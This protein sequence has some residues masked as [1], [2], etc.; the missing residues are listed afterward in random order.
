[1]DD[2]RTWCRTRHNGGLEGRPS[3]SWHV[4]SH[5]ARCSSH[6]KAKQLTGLQLNI[7]NEVFIRANPARTRAKDMEY[8]SISD[9]EI[10]Y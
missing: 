6:R 9:T 4:L 8:S 1:M 5:S 2:D 7:L 3:F 10:N